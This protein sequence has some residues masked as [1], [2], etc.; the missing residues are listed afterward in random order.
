MAVPDTLEQRLDAVRQTIASA[1]AHCGRSESEVRLIGVTKT[2]S[3]EAI[4]PAIACGLMDLGENYIQEFKQKA[5]QLPAHLRW[6]FIGHLQR[7]KAVWAAKYASFVHSVDSLPLVRALDRHSAERSEPLKCL[8]Q[9]RLGDEE[10]KSGLDP[11]KVLPFLDELAADP[12]SS[13]C[14][15]GLMTVPPPV[16]HADDNR[17]HFSRLR[18]LLEKIEAQAYRFWQGQE[19]SMGMSEDYVAAIEEGATMVRIGRAIFGSRPP[20]LSV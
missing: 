9:V 6:H 18:G 8:L 19:L 2:F 15:V 17:V 3:A 5:E 13:I 20:K 14:F 12:P 10:S 11:D 16:E 4:K 7:N 1:C